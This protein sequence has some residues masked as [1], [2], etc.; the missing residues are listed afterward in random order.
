MQ[1][2][3]FLTSLPVIA[4]G[5]AALEYLRRRD[6]VRR[7]PFKHAATSVL[8]Q[9]IAHL[10]AK[11]WEHGERADAAARLCQWYTYDIEQDLIAQA[12]LDLEPLEKELH[13]R[14]MELSK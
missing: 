14:E 1:F 4:V 11:Q 3:E 13:Q 7:R 5:W 12:A 6:A 10:K 2:P 8:L 9:R